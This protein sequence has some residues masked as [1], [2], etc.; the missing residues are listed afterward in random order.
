MIAN[1]RT[2]NHDLAHC[3]RDAFQGAGDRT[4]AELRGGTAM[5]KR[6]KVLVVEGEDMLAEDLYVCLRLHACD[7]RL[8][9]SA[10][11]ALAVAGDFAPD[12]LIFDD[13]DKGTKGLRTLRTIRVRHPATEGIL[14][15]NRGASAPLG[16]STSH[17]VR[18]ILGRDFALSELTAALPATGRTI[19]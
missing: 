12:V 2:K 3:L 18:R 5:G 16:R 4:D 15:A 17:G 13:P 10:D 11:R 6:L 7:V 1:Y 14:I 9:A 8:V 19:Q